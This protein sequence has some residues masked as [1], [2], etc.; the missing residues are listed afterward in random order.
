MAGS[1]PLS[2]RS[3]VRADVDMND[4]GSG[5]TRAHPGHEGG[6]KAGGGGRG[7]RAAETAGGEQGASPCEWGGAAIWEDDLL[8]CPDGAEEERRGGRGWVAA[9]AGLAAAPLVSAEDL[10]WS[11]STLKSL[12][13]IVEAS[14]TQKL[15]PAGRVL[16][17]VRPCSSAADGASA[18][19]QAGEG[20]QLPFRAHQFKGPRAI[21]GTIVFTRSMLTDHMPMSY[22][23]ALDGETAGSVRLL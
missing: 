7:A 11:S 4:G 3:A 23:H 1:E 20:A 16:W 13:S 14:E 6:R 22:M 5:E 21:F 12:E 2:P 9:A 17:V 18:A 19:R 10:E 8:D 15:L